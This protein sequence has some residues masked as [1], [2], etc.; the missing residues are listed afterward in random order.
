M[1]WTDCEKLSSMSIPESF[2]MFFLVA[3]LNKNHAVHL[4]IFIFIAVS[5]NKLER[6]IAWQAQKTFSL[7]QFQLFKFRPSKC[8]QLRVLWL[9]RQHI[10]V[11][12]RY[13]LASLS[14]ALK[15]TDIFFPQATCRLFACKSNQNS[16]YVLCW[17]W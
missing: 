6:T 10:P 5:L 3:S 12:E 1:I 8:D 11:P 16:G 14:L 7:V 2:V 9:L 4:N 15:F 17:L 13:V